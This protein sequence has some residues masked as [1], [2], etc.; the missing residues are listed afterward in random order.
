MD[1]IFANWINTKIVTTQYW[2]I[3]KVWVKVED[4]KNFLDT[5]DSNWWVNLN[6]MTSKDWKTK[7][8]ELDTW[9]PDWKAKKN[10]FGDDLLE[11]LPF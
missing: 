5:Y 2:E 3:I 11:E 10:E 8:F 6:I 9:K 7:Y 1:K 4:F